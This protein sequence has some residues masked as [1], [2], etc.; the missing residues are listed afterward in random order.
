MQDIDIKDI[1]LCMR[2]LGA[3]AFA[4]FGPPTLPVAGGDVRIT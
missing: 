3:L 2:A 4:F 1:F